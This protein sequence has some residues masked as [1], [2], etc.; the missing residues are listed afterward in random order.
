MVLVIRILMIKKKL[1]NKHT[2]TILTEIKYITI[3]MNKKYQQ[4]NKNILLH[5]N[6]N[7]CTKV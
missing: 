6:N 7:I 1:L 5:I 2:I 3:I 4:Q